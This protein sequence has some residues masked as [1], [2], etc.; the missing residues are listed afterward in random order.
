MLKIIIEQV[1]IKE[2]FDYWTLDLEE[3]DL[4]Y[5]PQ[6]LKNKFLGKE[7]I[8]SGYTFKIEGI[9]FYS[10]HKDKVILVAVKQ[11]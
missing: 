11:E 4:E 9:E 8:H 3:N 2:K 5:N 7:T 1:A 10:I 6:E